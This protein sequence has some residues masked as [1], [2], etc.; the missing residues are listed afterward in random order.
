MFL[1]KAPDHVHTYAT[2]IK[3]LD[4]RHKK[5]ITS[6]GYTHERFRLD[7]KKEDPKFWLRTEVHQLMYSME[8][9]PKS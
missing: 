1:L 4:L 3:D 6:F 8:N 7:T 9:S 2:L 5:K